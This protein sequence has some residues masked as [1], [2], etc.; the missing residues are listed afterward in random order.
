MAARSGRTPP[1]H[2]WSQEVLVPNQGRRSADQPG[3]LRA[4]WGN[5]PVKALRRLMFPSSVSIG[6]SPLLS[7]CISSMAGCSQGFPHT[8][9][10][11]EGG[12]QK[13]KAAVLWLP[14][15]Q[16]V[17]PVGWS[18]SKEALRMSAFLSSTSFGTFLLLSNC[19]HSMEALSL[20]SPPTRSCM[21]PGGACPKP[22]KEVC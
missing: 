8:H 14:A 18:E 17:C 5:Q 9:E 7:D 21:E 6:T 3:C 11:P 12:A 10:P 1:T 16:S 13:P 15:W 22:R 20:R 19:F 2:A 4:Q